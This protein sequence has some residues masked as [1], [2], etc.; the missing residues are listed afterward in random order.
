MKLDSYLRERGLTSVQFAEMSGIASK[1]AVHKYR[2][3]L[4]FPT[5]ENL[6]R[7]REATKGAVTADDFVDQH[8]G[9]SPSYGVPVPP[10]PTPPKP[11]RKR[12]APSPP[13]T[14]EAAD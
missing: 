14:T 9:A 4:R 8:A 11:R 12:A 13:R 3:G 2:H 5:P 7:I 10:P 6:R 1:Q